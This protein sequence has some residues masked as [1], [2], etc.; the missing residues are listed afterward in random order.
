M[1][2]LEE[3]K[4]MKKTE[5][6][7]ELKRA[8]IELYKLSLAVTSR[9]SKETAKLKALRKYIARVKTLK[10][11]MKREQAKTSPKSSVTK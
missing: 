10:Q 4:Q 8:Y 9:Q 5:L 7:S 2:T 3:L 11:M 1:I 6:S